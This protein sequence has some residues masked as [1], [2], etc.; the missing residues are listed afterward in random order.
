MRGV[1]GG[2]GRSDCGELG[3]RKEGCGVIVEDQ[4]ETNQEHLDIGS[5]ERVL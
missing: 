1:R 5:E 4:L 2:R 3:T